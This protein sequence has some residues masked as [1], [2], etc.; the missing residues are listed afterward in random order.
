VNALRKIHDALIPEGVVVDTQPVSAL[1]PVESDSGPLGPLDMREWA[2]TIRSIDGRIDQALRE[3]LFE[4]IDTAHFVVS[5]EYDDGQELV[6]VTR[7][8]QGTVVHEALARRV[9]RERR[10]V[11]LDQAVRLRVLRA[12]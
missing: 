2:R 11:R 7:G 8:W 1:P 10:P 12:R 3:G 9:A 6:D 5:D 4:L